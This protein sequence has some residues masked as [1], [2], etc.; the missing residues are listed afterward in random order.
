MRIRV[1]AD[2]QTPDRAPLRLAPGDAVRVG[3]RDDEWPAFVFASAEKGE[4]WVPERILDGAR[5]DAVVREAYDTQELAVRSGDIVRLLHD[6]AES[7]WSW[8][9]DALG[10]EGWIPHRALDLAADHWFVLDHAAAPGVRSVFTHPDFPQHVAFLQ[11]LRA[12][13]LLVAAGPLPD[14]EGAGMTIVHAPDAA[15]ALEV[16]RAAQEDDRAVTAGILRV[17]AREWN[18]MVSPD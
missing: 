3:E 6:D 17:R 9:R 11:S 1:T 8:C 2:H 15:T 7:G 4:G 18:V 16:L 10:D 12:R 5:P 14:E 13:G